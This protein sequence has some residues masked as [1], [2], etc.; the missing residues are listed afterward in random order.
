MIKT[1]KRKLLKNSRKESLLEEIDREIETRSIVEERRRTA[2]RTKES[3]RA[4]RLVEGEGLLLK[5]VVHLQ[6]LQ[7]QVRL[8]DVYELSTLDFR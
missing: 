8:H 5:A 2:E 7:A 4:R 6:V 1:T 3:T